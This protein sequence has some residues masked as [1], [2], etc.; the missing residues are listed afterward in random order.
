MKPALLLAA[1][2]ALHPQMPTEPADTLAHARIK[3]VATML[4]LPRY[5]CVQTIDRSYFTRV[6]AKNTAIPSC[7]QAGADTKSGQSSLRL[8]ATDRLRLDVAQ[9]DRGEIHS[10]PGASHFETGDIDELIGRGPV[11]T[12][13][14]GGYLVD[15]FA[16]EGAHFDF[17][18]ERASV[19]CR[20]FTFDYSVPQ[21][22]SHYK[23]RAGN[24][25]V[26]S[27]Y[28]GTFD[29]DAAS[30]E[31]LRIT[32]EASDLPQE[33]GLCEADSALDYASVRIGSGDFLLPR[34]SQ[35]H[36]VNRGTVETNNTTVCK[37]CQEY[38]AESVVHYDDDAGAAGTNSANP[39]SSFAL[40]KG[41][42]FTLRLR[43]EIDSNVAAAGDP[44]SATV[45]QAARDPKSKAVLIPTG[46]VVR[47]RISRMEHRIVPSPSFII[48]IAWL[49][50]EVG[51]VSSPL[52]ANPASRPAAPAAP[53]AL[54]LSMQRRPMPVG[55]PDAL[56][57]PTFEKH[58]NSF[59]RGVDIANMRHKIAPLIE[60]SSGSSGGAVTTTR[61]LLSAAEKIFRLKRSSHSRSLNP[62]SARN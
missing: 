26:I 7:S 34:Q 11:S 42:P 52:A 18:S 49:S 32:V 57:F 27:A 20:I 43:T 21:P 3:I 10:W 8:D 40:P 4:R 48:G 28:Y 29:V 44:V 62:I 58:Y 9:G 2:A 46:A 15:I 41:L 6:A 50:V 37:D 39:P 14:F 16:N 36:L 55:P 47:G 56:L 1:A 45:S 54:S 17:L 53:S 25:W 59:C 61:D 12:G 38:R 19:G 33:T 30:L 60:G 5:A 22:K 24:G 31:L 35:L 13:S 23:I 51:G